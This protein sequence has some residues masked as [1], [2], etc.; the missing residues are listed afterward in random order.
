MRRLNPIQVAASACGAVLSALLASLFGVTGTV[1]GV[2]VGS[3]VATTATAVIWESVERTHAKVRDVVVRNTHQLPL[4]QRGATGTATGRVDADAASSAVEATVD[5]GR[6]ARPGPADDVVGPG[7]ED[8]GE[9][10]LVARSR[11]ARTSPTPPVGAPRRRRARWPLVVTVGASFVL[12]L[13][14]VTLVEVAAGRPLSS[15]IGS[16]NVAGGTS[17]GRLLTSTPPPAT[18][19]MTTTTT[20]TTTPATTTPATTTPATTTTTT[21][22]TSGSTSTSTTTTTT[23][24]TTSGTAP[25]RGS[26]GGGS[27]ARVPGR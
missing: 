22:P 1:I 8:V 25:A 4:L 12:A 19:A 20:T 21:P 2:A 6:T 18:H 11:A 23:T 13:A 15:L 9:L 10:R 26:S 3:V 16:S 24:T 14:L 17:A 5:A 27:G 7:D